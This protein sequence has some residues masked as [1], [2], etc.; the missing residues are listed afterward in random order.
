[1]SRPTQSAA[2]QYV[3]GSAKSGG[4]TLE[5]ARE[6]LSKQWAVTGGEP[7]E[8]EPRQMA[9]ASWDGYLDSNVRHNTR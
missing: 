1:M 7:V 4:E 6:R 3:I 2:E 8:P 5:S 9:A